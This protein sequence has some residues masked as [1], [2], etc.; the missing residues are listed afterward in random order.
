[1]TAQPDTLRALQRAG[2]YATKWTARRDE[3]IRQAV[4]EGGSLREVGNAAGMSHQA[5][6]FIVNGRG[7]K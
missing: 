6:N 2:A 3:L 4:A 7:P 1:M 5:V